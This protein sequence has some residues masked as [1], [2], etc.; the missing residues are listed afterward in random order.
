[1]RRSRRGRPGAATGCSPPAKHQVM[2]FAKWDPPIAYGTRITCTG[3]QFHVETG[4]PVKLG[5]DSHPGY[6]RREGIVCASGCWS[7]PASRR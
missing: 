6:A 1:V 5:E 2:Q 3:V 7:T 4:D